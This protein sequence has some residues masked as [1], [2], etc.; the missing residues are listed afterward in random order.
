MNARKQIAAVFALAGLGL[1]AFAGLSIAYPMSARPITDMLLAIVG[2]LIAFGM[3]A[4][5]DLWLP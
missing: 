5:I 2:A 3:G 1:T 4:M